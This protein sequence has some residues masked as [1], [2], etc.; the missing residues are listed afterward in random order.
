VHHLLQ[1]GA[2]G[3]VILDA[4]EEIV[5]QGILGRFAHLAEKHGAALVCLTERELGSMV[6][7]RLKTRLRRLSPGVFRCELDVAKDKRL[8]PTPSTALV[9]HGPPGLC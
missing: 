9:F 5:P 1:S 3:M 7:L 4:R 2:F 6:S 8:G